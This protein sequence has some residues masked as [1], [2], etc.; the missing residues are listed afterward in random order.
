MNRGR[1]DSVRK[2]RD[3]E[4]KRDEDAPGVSGKKGTAK[5]WRLSSG[6][7]DPGEGNQKQIKEKNWLVSKRRT[8][9]QTRVLG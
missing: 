2:I 5:I 6:K 8:I 7:F 1:T 4:G 3:E 9:L